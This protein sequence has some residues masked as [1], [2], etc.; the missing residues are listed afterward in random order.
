ML[1][2]AGPLAAFIDR[3]DQHH[4]SAQRA[5]AAQG[6]EPLL[7]TC[8]CFAEAMHLLG[9]SG[10]YRYQSVLLD[11][12][13]QGLLQIHHLTAEEEI[14]AFALLEQYRDRPMDYADASLVAVAESMKITRILTFDSDFRFYR[15]QDG[16]TLEVAP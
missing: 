12:V 8:P 6:D 2:D 10:G 15:M 4:Q 16:T 1:T 9:D 7:T 5:L 13:H 14:R 3:R 11:M